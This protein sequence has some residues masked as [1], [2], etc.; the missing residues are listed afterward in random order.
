MEPKMR[1]ILTLIS[2]AYQHSILRYI[3]S[4]VINYIGKMDALREYP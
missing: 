4:E 2:R 3:N 1:Q